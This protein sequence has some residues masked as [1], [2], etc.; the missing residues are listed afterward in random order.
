MAYTEETKLADTVSLPTSAIGK[1]SAGYLGELQLQAAGVE[2]AKRYVCS[3]AALLQFMQGRAAA[4]L[5]QAFFTA[6]GIQAALTTWV[7]K[8]VV[9]CIV[10]CG[11]YTPPAYSKMLPYVCVCMAPS[12]ELISGIIFTIR[13]S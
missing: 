4:L 8:T 9:F 3:V 13:I 10:H 11:S 12:K 2:G 1:L 5:L 7:A 6:F